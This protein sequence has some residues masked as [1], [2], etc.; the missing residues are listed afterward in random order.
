MKINLNQIIENVSNFKEM[1]YKYNMFLQMNEYTFVMYIF[2]QHA[3]INNTHYILQVGRDQRLFQWISQTD[4][5][6][7]RG[8]NFHSIF[9]THIG[10]FL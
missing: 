10:R 5:K 6:L 1:M 4:I 7:T 8:Y 3:E 2:S 9:S